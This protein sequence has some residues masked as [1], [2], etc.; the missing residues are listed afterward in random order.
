MDVSHITLV[1]GQT[2]P[3]YTGIKYDNPDK[4]ML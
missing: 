3:V 4:V 2:S 1:G